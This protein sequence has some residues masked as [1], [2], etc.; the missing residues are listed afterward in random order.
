MKQGLKDN[1]YKVIKMISDIV[2]V[3]DTWEETMMKINDKIKSQ[4]VGDKLKGKLDIDIKQMF[5]EG[6]RIC[7]RC[8]RGLRCPI[9]KPDLDMHLDAKPINFFVC[10]DGS[11]ASIKALETVH[12]G[13]MKEIDKIVAANVWS[14]EKEDSMNYKFKHENVKALTEASCCGLGKRF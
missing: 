9:H 4:Q 1:D 13:I 7:I 2:D 8:K 14:Q 12:Y 6:G 11:D 3:H 5:G 10:H